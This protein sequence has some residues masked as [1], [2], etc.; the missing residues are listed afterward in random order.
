MRPNLAHG[1]A[2]V[3]SKLTAQIVIRLSPLVLERAVEKS[4]QVRA[5]MVADLLRRYMWA[6]GRCVGG[7]S[8]PG[9][10]SE[11]AS[12]LQ[13][14]PC[15]FDGVRVELNLEPAIVWDRDQP[16]FLGA[17]IE[18]DNNAM[19]ELEDL[20]YWR[21]YVHFNGPMPKGAGLK[22]SLSTRTEV[23]HDRERIDVV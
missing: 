16:E 5:E 18:R 21:D 14:G 23:R 1:F 20:A 17:I 22:S 11:L 9:Q 12:R 19:P 13:W 10:L 4:N 6:R 15:E 7:E 2:A 8:P 3:H